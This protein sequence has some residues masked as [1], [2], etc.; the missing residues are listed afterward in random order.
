MIKV[1]IAGAAGRMGRNL[2]AACH[3]AEGLELTVATEHA[4]SSF[5]GVDAGELCG[6]GHK[7][8]PVTSDMNALLEA[9][10]FIDFTSIE[11]TKEHVA[12][13]KENDKALVIGTTGFTDE[14]VALAKQSGWLVKGLGQRILKMETAVIGACFWA[15][16]AFSSI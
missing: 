5:I 16:E 1:A 9:D 12:W 10:V 2:I 11:S 13:C 4:G 3:E 8:C 14:E 6:L 15:R 7:G